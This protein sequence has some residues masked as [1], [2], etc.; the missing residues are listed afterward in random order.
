MPSQK[1]GHY[2]TRPGRQKDFQ[3]EYDHAKKNRK[4]VPRRQLVNTLH[5]EDVQL[6]E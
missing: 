1:G 2:Q 5:I 6:L 4:R 3:A